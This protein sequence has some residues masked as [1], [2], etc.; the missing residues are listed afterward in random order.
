MS[1]TKQFRKNAMQ[2]TLILLMCI[3]TSMVAQDAKVIKM[4][5]TNS[6]KFTKTE[7]TAQAG[8]KITIKLTTVSKLPAAAMSHNFVLLKQSAD[9]RKIAMASAKFKKNDYIAPKMEDQ[10]IA[11]TAMASGGETVEITFTVP[12]KPG[13]YTYICTFPGHFLAGMKGTL[14]VK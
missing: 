11:H 2:F 5:G 4:E 6:M 9:S 13:A 3:S 7:I 10:I 8:Q 12:K 14:I 1:T